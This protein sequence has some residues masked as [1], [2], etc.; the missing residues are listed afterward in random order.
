MDLSHLHLRHRALAEQHR[1]PMLDWSALPIPAA[2]QVLGV[3]PLFMVGTLAVE[4]RADLGFSN[5]ALGA[6]VTVFSGIAAVLSLPAGRLVERIG[7]RRGLVAGAA[8]TGLALT[9]SAIGADHWWHLAAGQAVAAVGVAVTMPSVQMALATCIPPER[10]GIAFGFNLSSI[11]A[12]ILLAGVAVPLLGETVGW[13]WA[14]GGSGVA[15][16]L[17]AAT[18]L[19]SFGHAEWGPM[20]KQH[21]PVDLEV[22]LLAS[23]AMF[24]GVWGSQTVATFSVESGVEQGHTP[25]SIGYVLAMASVASI[26]IRIVSGVTA[27]RAGPIRAFGVMAAFLAIGG[28]GTAVLAASGSF[29]AVAVGAVLGLGVGWSWNGLA[30]YALVRLNPKEAATADR[31]SAPSSSA[32]LPRTRASRRV[33]RC[34]RWRWP[35]GPC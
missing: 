11:P 14:F 29:A 7:H 35:P 31:P 16:L 13:R 30:I 10:Q 12:A 33:G 22:V 27:D 32:P 23:A 26:A 5:V 25:G 4:I 8:L 34:R 24:L 28:V 2:A 1:A 3:L 17:L 9:T 6:L 20:Y 18:A 21:H 15:A 19:V